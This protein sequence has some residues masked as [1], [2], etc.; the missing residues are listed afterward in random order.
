[1]CQ[2]LPRPWIQVPQNLEG[3]ESIVQAEVSM[4]T[5]LFYGDKNQRRQ[6]MKT[7]W[8]QAWCLSGNPTLRQSG[9]RPTTC[10]KPVRATHRHSIKQIK[11]GKKKTVFVILVAGWVTENHRRGALLPENAEQRGPRGQTGS[12]NHKTHSYQ[13][14]VCS[15]QKPASSKT[16]SIYSVTRGAAREEASGWKPELT[17]QRSW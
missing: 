11:T 4:K 16:A 12:V 14:G 13:R 2:V 3:P 17:A 10:L 6:G 15:L 9:R 8:C 7:V 1:M 5:A